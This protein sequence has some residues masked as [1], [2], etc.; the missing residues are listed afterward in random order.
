MLKKLT[1]VILSIAAV[2]SFACTQPLSAAADD[3]GLTITSFE[4]NDENGADAESPAVPDADAGNAD[5]SQPADTAAADALPFGDIEK[6]TVTEVKG[7][8]GFIGKAADSPD[9]SNAALPD[10]TYSCDYV[11]SR[12][13]TAEKKFWD[14]IGKA[15]DS[16][17]YSSSDFAP[18]LN[19]LGVSYL[20]YGT[21]YSA[22]GKSKAT[23]LIQIFMYSN[24]QYYFLRP[25]CSW[26]GNYIA[27][28][29][30]TDFNK[31]ANRKKCE[32]SLTTVT[33]S[34]MRSLDKLSDPVEKEKFIIDHISAKL[35]Y[36]KVAAA[37]ILGGG[38]T[39]GYDQSIAGAFYKKTAV[40]A[41]YSQAFAYFCNAAGMPCF[42]VSSSGHQWNV[43]K[44]YGNWYSVDITW[45]D[46]A[47]TP[48]AAAKWINKSYAKFKA[49]DPNG[50]HTYKTS[51]WSY[52]APP[53]CKYN[54]IQYPDPTGYRVMV[55]GGSIYRGANS[56]DD[57]VSFI[58]KL[59]DTS[60]SYVITFNKSVTE[61]TI[62]FPKYAASVTLATAKGVT[63]STS[64]VSLAPKTNLI[65]DCSIANTAKKSISVKVP[66]NSTLT[67]SRADSV[68]GKITGQ[69]S[70]T[71]IVN[72]AATAD[73]VG[74]IGTVIINSKASLKLT[75]NGKLTANELYMKDASGITLS[76][77][78]LMKVT[79]VLS[80]TGSPVITMSGSCKPIDLSAKKVSGKI[81]LRSSDSFAG[82]QVAK[83]SK[84]DPNLIFDISGLVPAVK[85]GSYKYRLY[86][87]SGKAT[88]MPF[89][90]SV[91]GR[92]YAYWND[93]ISDLSKGTGSG[94]CTVE[95]LGD[96]DMGTSFK[97]PSGKFRGTLTINGNSH[98]MYFSGT[99]TA[100]LSCNTTFKNVTFY[101]FKSLKLRIPTGT[102]LTL[103]GV[104][105][106][107]YV[108]LDQRGGR[109]SGSIQYV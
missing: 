83:A 70:S 62:K 63:L 92:L 71:L 56:L 13:T 20:P 55:K 73:T 34:W 75:Q 104:K 18:R 4:E 72:A 49:Q 94:V 97:M 19:S 15:C 82:R 65:F 89:V 103:S 24:P 1:S 86:V 54:V 91:N 80:G 3:E 23:T 101:P 29:I 81:Y 95:L 58:D 42:S 39:K 50:H 43:V 27:P 66:A 38:L 93:V 41:A 69:K 8:G 59:K 47:T 21:D 107:S 46:M 32:S 12:L 16:F 74:T 108:E 33:R 35:T 68:F 60:A 40:C 79:S 106:A 6:F 88:A 85:D 76:S 26:Q 22:I 31:S 90:F 102:T 57:I 98:I 61:K 48:A 10:N 14:Q 51:V 96:C 52:I 87:K 109:I 9:T 5:A 25:G 53:E 100:S 2:F 84:V 30:I 17:M 37:V 67:I 64:T 105:A 7:S 77:G 44:I 99:P 11:Y 28:N 36:D 45:Y 78:A